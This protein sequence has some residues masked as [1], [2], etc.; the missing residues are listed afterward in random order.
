M[1]VDVDTLLNNLKNKRDVKRRR[2]AYLIRMQHVPQ[3]ISCELCESRIQ[4]IYRSAIST[5][6]QH[7][8]R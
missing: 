7:Y 2:I 4:L 5:T 1:N 6:S 3:Q 8:C